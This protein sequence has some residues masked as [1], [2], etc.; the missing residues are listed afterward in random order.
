MRWPALFV[1]IAL[2]APVALAQAADGNR[3][4]YLDQSDPYYVG[5]SFPKLTTPQWVGEEGVEAVVILAIDDMRGHEAW[6]AFL[7]PVI[8]RLKAIDG[9]APLSIMTC[10]IDPADPHLKKWLA[11]GLSLEIHTVDHPCPCLQG[12][13]FAKAKSTYD[14]CVDLLAS[15]PGNKPVCFRMPCCDS[16][17]TLS[18]RF[19]AEIFNRQTE[20]GNFL[21][22]DSSVFNVI[23]ADDPE[24][25][26]EL[27]LNANGAEI[28]RRYIPFKSFVNTIEN[29][30]YPFVIGRLCWEFPCVVPTD[31]SANHV[32]QA[33]N[34][35]TVADWQ[36]A[37]DATVLKQGVFDL[38][39][40]P[41]GWIRNDQIVQLVDYAVKRHGRKVRFLNFRQAHERLTKNLLLGQTLRAAD[42][43]DNG[44]R[45]LDLNADGYL[46]VV[47]GN[48]NVQQTRLWSP[49]KNAWIDG[50]LPTQLVVVKDGR[51]RD[52]GA[53]FGIAGPEG[54]VA[55]ILQNENQS[56]AWTFDGQQWV[57]DRSLLRGLEVD[58]QPI[59]T[60]DQGVDRG[61]RLRDLDG[62]GNCELLV[63]NHQQQAAFTWSS[64][65]RVWRRLPFSLPDGVTLVDAQGRDAGLR[66]VDVDDDLRA[67]LVFSNEEAFSLHLFDSMETGWS[68]KILD[69]QR[70]DPDGLPMITRNGANNGAWFHSRHLW[71]QNEDTSRQPDLV[72]RRS[73]N[74][75]L[76]GEM[77]GAK[78]PAASLKAL[79]AR[80][81]FV[82]E[83]AAAEPLVMDPIAMAWGPDGRLWVVEMGDYPLGTDGKGKHG[84]VVR[85]LEDTDGDGRYDRSTVFLDGLGFPT[86]VAPWRNGVLVTCAPEIFY[87]E[88]TDGDGKADKRV[89]LFEGFNEGNQ[90]HRVNGLKWGLDG[91]LYCANGDSGG[92]IKSLKTGQEV[93][94]GSQD[95]RIKPDEGLIDPQSGQ[96]QFGRNRDDW[97]NWFG[98]NNAN[99]MYHFVLEDHYLRRNPHVPAIDARVQVSVEPGAAPVFPRSR[100]L[101]RY[102]DFHMANRFTS[103]NSAMIY[104]D[105]LFG[106]AYEGNSFISEPVHNLV[107]REVMSADGFTFTSRRAD[108]EQESEFLA[109]TDNWFRPTMLQT[110]PDGALWVADMY[111]Q[112][113]EHPEWIPLD[114]QRR[115]DL[116][117]G[118]D[119]GRLYR[120]YP[121]DKKPRKIPRL[122]KLS[123]AE[124]VAALDSPSG[125]QRDMAQQLLTWRDDR[126]AVP[127][128]KKL[129]RES[130][131]PIC[132]AQALCTLDTLKAIEPAVLLAALGDRHPGVRRHAVRLAGPLLAKSPELASALVAMSADDDLQVQ[133]QR[134]Y[135]LG[136]WNDPRAGEALAELA[137][138]YRNGPWMTAAVLSSLNA[139]NLDG[140]LAGVLKGSGRTPPANLVEQ[141]VG[142]A[143]AFGNQKAIGTSLG[144]IARPDARG[145]YET[146]QLTALGG[147]LDALARRRISLEKIGAQASDL[148][149]ATEF[150][151]QM[152]GQEDADE[153]ARAAAVRLLARQPAGRD[154]DIAALGQLLTPRT[155]GVVQAAAVAALARIDDA[156]VPEVLLAGWRGHGPSL[157]G[158]I[159]D[160]LLSRK[161]WVAELLARLESGQVL[162]ADIDAA[163]RQS[164]LRINNAELRERA[165]ALL[166]GA[167]SSD[168]QKVLEEFQKVH[169]LTGDPM[170][171]GA[172]FTKRCAV[173]HQLRGAG[174]AVGPDLGSIT[175]YSS[176]GLLTAILDPNR[177]VE[178]RFVD[179]IA[180]TEDGLTH[181]G[182]LASETG[183][184][185]TLVGQEGKQQ[186]ILR[187]ELES[188]TSSGKSLM[189]EGVEK[190]LSPQD[191]ADV[192][193]YVRG[194][195]PPRKEF[196][197]SRPAIVKADGGGSLHLLATN[198]EIFGGTLILEDKY[199]N[200]GFW[201]SENDRAVWTLDVPAAGKYSVRLH[202]ACADNS[203]NNTLVLIAGPN[204]LA[205][206]I[207]GT[208]SWDEYRQVALG[209]LQLK[210]G[211]QQIIAHAAP[212]VTGAMLDLKEIE[213]KRV[214]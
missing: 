191:L 150:A 35:Q 42:G 189:P 47:I 192:I 12:G 101:T 88:D 173:C 187:S 139:Q 18:P 143:V 127:L 184:N 93:D 164:L 198:C 54:R 126:A 86:G 78:T 4:V 72:E 44:V 145:H 60:A 201:Q 55:L 148:K 5:R 8:E 203:A 195:G 13:D 110:G 10:Q 69:G 111:R 64:E 190:D 177:A 105:D 160:V 100:T 17:N 70:G 185:I 172:V 212:G 22:L 166:A 180:V 183:N 178:A 1:L 82:V 73:F 56:G 80:P 171:G 165:A 146:W 76:K 124:L 116:R 174:S 58:G 200:L 175:D 149:A 15:V 31:W 29:Y 121:V 211:R 167:V 34:P 199:K 24:L 109:S 176:Q 158:Q 114:W 3:L 45:L 179:Y 9:D 28:F 147:L 207:T 49:K 26:R 202:Y 16:L 90:Q 113:I 132:R 68:R 74:D 71:V 133:L 20:R 209:E 51:R 122:D 25:P 206:K 61:V 118:H 138:D 98:C 103:A 85:F 140:V 152:V 41:H 197:D 65:K 204:T 79:R 153:D 77:P 123:T 63:S 102:N 53:R 214:K 144:V 136:E 142:L 155:S 208:D 43:Q 108:D 129:A 117:A 131:R 89:T 97:G 95:F 7:R 36:F 83:P 57:E 159:L 39:F 213:L 32:Q 33:N 91:W 169:E 161:A 162:P 87:A 154:A 11:E 156:R 128:L 151:R 119:M 46:D 66:L 23:T 19:F 193:A 182:I 37:L 181:T 112:T 50:P 52:A 134:A 92:R 205:T 196:P 106:Q 163:R 130:R 96:S 38:V 99:P 186:V 6:E 141:L 62:D 137:L 170:A 94:L 157:R 27:V 120:V 40:H 115:L 14:R 75:M 107:H 125:W 104:R 59:L 135:A 188:L 81:G 48:E 84:G 194:A 30:P 67:D 168:R 21:A 210:P 2:L